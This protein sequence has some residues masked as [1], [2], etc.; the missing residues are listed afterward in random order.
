MIYQLIK[1]DFCPMTVTIRK[2]ESVKFETSWDVVYTLKDPLNAKHR[3]PGCRKDHC[4]D[5]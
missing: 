5:R 3:C 1:C 4:E 2:T